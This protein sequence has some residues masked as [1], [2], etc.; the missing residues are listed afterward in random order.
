MRPAIK[1]VG[2]GLT[3][4]PWPGKGRNMAQYQVIEKHIL[5]DGVARVTRLGHSYSFDRLYT[6]DQS[7]DTVTALTEEEAYRLLAD[8]IQND[9]LEY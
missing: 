4:G 7:P 9:V 2:H 5:S 1:K 3:K 8:S 6:E